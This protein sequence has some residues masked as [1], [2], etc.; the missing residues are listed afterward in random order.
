MHSTWNACWQLSSATNAF[1]RDT[2]LSIGSR[3]IEQVSKSGLRT[4]I[5][6]VDGE[7]PGPSRIPAASTRARRSP[8]PDAPEDAHGAHERQ[9]GRADMTGT[10][11]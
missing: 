7:A 8:S 1:S 2:P 11:F 10:S 4:K 6:S 3:Q 5:V 9:V